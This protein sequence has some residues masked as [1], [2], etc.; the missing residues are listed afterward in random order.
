MAPG[1]ERVA[2]FAA[3]RWE[4]AA[5]VRRLRRVRRE[6]VAAFTVWRAE[7]PAGETWIVKT[8]IGTERAGAA[9]ATVTA[10]HPFRLLLSSGCA[11]ALS[12]DLV[13][14]D[15]AV[16]T[17]VIGSQTGERFDTDP[18][19]RALACAAAAQADIRT[20]VGPVLCSS[21]VLATPAAKQAAAASTG[22]VAVDMEG[23][24]IAACARRGG[25]PFASVR[26]I[27]D[28]A[29]TELRSAGVFMDPQTGG[30][31]PLR[32]LGHLAQ[33][34]RAVADLLALRR[35]MLAAQH[36]LDQFFARFLAP[37]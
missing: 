2:V 25:I 37:Q 8:G 10:M 1:M 30:V 27:L 7:T 24:A 19:S 17:A 11:G 21:T 35:M 6:R 14:G 32:L 18:S 23:A 12:P 34:P 4:C 16:A 29:A 13:P 5:I 22:A 33:Q 31:R 9:A 36:G 20:A 26:A 15:L 3:L 28:T